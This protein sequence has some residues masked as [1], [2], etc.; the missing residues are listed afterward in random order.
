[1][2]V[3]IGVGLTCGGVGSATRS[4]T[5]DGVAGCVGVVG[6]AVKALSKI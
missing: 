6:V 2:R 4:A 5:G 3:S 1:M